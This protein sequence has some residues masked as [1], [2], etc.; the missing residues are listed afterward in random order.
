M[1]MAGAKNYHMCL[2]LLYTILSLWKSLVLLYGF[3]YVVGWQVWSQEETQERLWQTKFH[4][5]TRLRDRRAGR[6]HGKDTGWSGA[7]RWSE[8]KTLSLSLDWG[9]QGRVE[10]T[11]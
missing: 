8:G 5:V 7:R 10:S 1:T 9:Q 2:S 4:T 6:P 3:P 11:V